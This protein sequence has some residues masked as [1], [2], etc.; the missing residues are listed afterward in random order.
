MNERPSE[1]KEG[2]RVYISVFKWEGTPDKTLKGSL[3]VKSSRK[4]GLCELGLAGEVKK[5]KKGVKVG[6]KISMKERRSEGIGWDE[7]GK[8]LPTKKKGSQKNPRSGEKI[9]IVKVSQ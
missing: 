7:G 9:R 3:V 8:K 2:G 5:K 1:W 6:G 4:G